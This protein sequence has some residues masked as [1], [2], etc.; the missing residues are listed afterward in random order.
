MQK[1]EGK[2]EYIFPTDRFEELL[3]NYYNEHMILYNS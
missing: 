3:K 1:I 2:E